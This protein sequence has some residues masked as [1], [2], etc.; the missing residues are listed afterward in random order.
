MKN[1]LVNSKFKE[2]IA[3]LKGCDGGNI[4]SK[5]WFCGIEWGDT[6]DLS[7]DPGY[8]FI[9]IEGFD[10]IPYFDTEVYIKYPLMLNSKV[11]L[12]ISKIMSFLRSKVLDLNIAK[13]YLR[14]DFCRLE[15]D[16][17]K[18]NLFPLPFPYDSDTLWNID[19]FEKTGIPTKEIYR[20][21]CIQNRFPIFQNAVTK[22]K[23]ALVIC[24]GSSY[25]NYYIQAFSEL[26]NI[27]KNNKNIKLGSGKNIE[28][29]E[30]Q[31]TLVIAPF[32]GGPKGLNSDQDIVEISKIVSNYLKM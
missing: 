6:I 29:I 5:I 10:Y 32:F 13:K 11:N 18:L 26:D 23:P 12:K 14:D 8:S 21:E 27:F 3:S 25:R 19:I 7:F 4:Q 24:F 9:K 28:I 1:D 17:F 22:F 15:G 2:Y 30:G 16:M 20:V 31:T